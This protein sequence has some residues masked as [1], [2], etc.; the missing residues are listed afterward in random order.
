MKLLLPYA[1]P[2]GGFLGILGSVVLGWPF[3]T[4]SSD[5]RQWDLL[6]TLQGKAEQRG[7]EA[8]HAG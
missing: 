4:E 5:R 3:I 6:K 7:S 2:V 8:A 1:D